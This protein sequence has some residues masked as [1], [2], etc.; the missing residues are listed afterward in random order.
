MSPGSSPFDERMQLRSYIETQVST[1]L[2]RYANKKQSDIVFTYAQGSTKI[3]GNIM[4]DST[5]DMENI[6]YSLRV[7]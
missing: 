7:A 2:N 1:V 6:E 5:K 3:I 4:A